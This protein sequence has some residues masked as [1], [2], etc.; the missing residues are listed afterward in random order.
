MR[1]PQ[2]GLF[3]SSTASAA[4]LYATFALAVMCLTVACSPTEP[5]ESRDAAESSSPI[6]ELK[7]I[8][9]ATTGSLSILVELAGESPEPRQLDIGR[10]PVCQ[11]GGPIYSE[12][13]VAEDGKLANVL[14]RV[15]GG[16]E[17]WRPPT[18]D[19]APVQ[20]LQSGCVYRPHVI[21]LQ[22]GTPLSV[23]NHDD[24]LHNV[25]LTSRRNSS[26]NR[27]QA[28][29]ADALT[30]DFRRPELSI[31]I[32]CDLHPW[33]GAWVHVLD[34]PWFAVTDAAGLGRIEQLP[35]GEY[36]LEAV[37]EKFG[38]KTITAKLGANE[39]IELR[40]TFGE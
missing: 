38:T 16:H 5:S 23:E 10:E 32:Q 17:S 22:L 6:S 25:H 9:P 30:F 4:S 3:L 29:G 39:T 20:I 28:A 19:T 24:L 33:M 35:P 26:S 34:H 40:F 18:A 13:V 1:I 2:H 7:A 21:G 15:A 31:P 14:V 37:H 11:H 36:Q 27:V 12:F 8:D